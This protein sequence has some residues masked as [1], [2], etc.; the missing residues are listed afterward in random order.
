MSYGNALYTIYVSVLWDKFHF[1]P[2][3]PPDEESKPNRG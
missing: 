3:P 2:P 1:P